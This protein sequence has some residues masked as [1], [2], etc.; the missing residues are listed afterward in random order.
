MVDARASA[1]A[2]AEARPNPQGLRVAGAPPSVLLRPVLTI[3]AEH[4]ERVELEPDARERLAKVA[5]HS[6]GIEV[7]QRVVDVR[8]S[9]KG[10]CD[11]F[12]R[13]FRDHASRRTAEFSYYVATDRTSQY[14]WSERS[15]AWRWPRPTTSEATAFLADAAVLSAVIR[16]DPSLVSMHASVVA[17]NGRIAA[18]AG[19][20]FA[21]KTTTAIAC[22]R[23]G[24]QFYSDERLLIRAGTVFPFQRTCSLRTAG[25]Q[26][27]D[28]DR[29]DDAFG[30]WL[31]SAAGADSEYLSVAELFGHQTIGVPGSLAA[32][33]V[34]SGHGEFPLIRRIGHYDAMPT[35][36]RWMDS[37]ELSVKRLAQLIDQI[38]NVPCFA[39]TLGSPRRTADAIA[40]TIEELKCDAA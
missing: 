9:E 39:L 26:L 29:L 34:L 7:A 22:V 23:R 36:L 6:S 2:V 19:D 4:L 32:I 37:R 40:A 5:V 13:R 3:S 14:F 10:A 1:T 30:A 24:M 21:G 15:Q 16:S 31:H 38:A 27:L 20:S 11:L 18:I 28:R 33:F 17:H 12:A 8:F 35:L 25:K